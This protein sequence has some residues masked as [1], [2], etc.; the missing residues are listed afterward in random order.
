ME[1]HEIVIL[2]LSILSVILTGVIAILFLRQKRVDID[3]KTIKEAVDESITNSFKLTLDSIER[4]NKSFTQGIEDKLS[5]IDKAI[6]EFDNKNSQTY[7]ALIEK[8]NQSL[9]Q[10]AEAVR[11]ENERAI[12]NLNEKFDS[13]SKNMSERYTLIGAGVDKA[14]NDLRRENAEKLT[15]IQATVDEKLQKTLDERLKASFES[16]VSQIGNVN[17]AIGEIK[18]IAGGVDALKNALTNVKAKGIV[19]EVILGNIITDVLTP[20]QYDV[21]VATKKGSEDVVEFAIKMPSNKDGDFTYLPLDSKFPLEPYNKLREAIDQ[22]DKIAIEQA[23]KELRQRIL[24]SAKDIS[25]KYI[26]P[27]TTTSFAV[28]FLPTEGLY[29]EAIEA[30]IFEEVQRK[31]RINIVGPSTLFAFLSSL[32]SGFDALAIQR[33]SNQVFTLLEA[34]KTEFDTFAKTLSSAKK[35]VDLASR[36]LDVL[37]NTRTNQMQKK[38]KNISKIT[39]GEAEQILEIEPSEDEDDE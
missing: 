16:V 10:M 29:V 37:T 22:G 9:T 36:E 11:T 39:L 26:D 14:L 21:N 38:L 27:P 33:H 7:L 1:P 5:L 19:G 12:K 13:F 31:Y 20:S 23:R 34:I 6:K 30:G 8:L 35:K 32:R 17:K 15:S 4:A 28:M 2:C 18:N 24:G 25:T 3:K